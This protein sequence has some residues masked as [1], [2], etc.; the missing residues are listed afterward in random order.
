MTEQDKVE[1]EKWAVD[2]VKRTVETVQHQ[3]MLSL[4][5]ANV[6]AQEKA[7]KDAKLS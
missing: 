3:V 4:M 2:L 7:I 6:A 1:L 5:A